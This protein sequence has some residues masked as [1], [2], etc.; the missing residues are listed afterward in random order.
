[1]GAVQITR[2]VSVEAYRRMEADSPTKHEYV[3]G[4]VRALARASDRHDRLALRIA[5]ALLLA[6]EARGC[7]VYISDLR[8]VVRRSGGELHYYPDVMVVCE[9][10]PDPYEKTR[11]CVLVEVLSPS[12]R[13]ADLGEKRVAYTSLDSLRTYLVF[14]QDRRWAVGYYRTEEGFEVRVWEGAGQVTVPCVDVTVDLETLY[15]GL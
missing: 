4:A 11:P 6:T 12:T 2:P 5:S 14:D 15:R 7:D 9:E 13:V 10:D 8:V 1:M 3:Q